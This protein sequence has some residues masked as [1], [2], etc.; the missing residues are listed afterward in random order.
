MAGQLG[1]RSQF[2]RGATKIGYARLITPPEP[3]RD[4]VDAT[5]LESPDFVREKV[6]GFKDYPPLEVEFIFVAG[7]TA[8]QQL[9]DDFLSGVVTP[10]AW[11]YKVCHNETG[12]VLYT[13]TFDGTID[14]VTLSPISTEELL[15]LRCRIQLTSSVTKS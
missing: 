7:D 3:S 12:A 15:L 1:Y 4:Q 14:L 8:Q 2:Y 13:Y 6:P 9:E 10:E 11:S 5:H